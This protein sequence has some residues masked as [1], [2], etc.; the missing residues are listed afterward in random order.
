MILGWLLAEIDG[1]PSYVCVRKS[2]AVALLFVVCI[3]NFA[4][5]KG[6]VVLLFRPTLFNKYVIY[7][8]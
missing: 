3:L 2:V 4:S 8:F 7:W 1:E 6:E 5:A